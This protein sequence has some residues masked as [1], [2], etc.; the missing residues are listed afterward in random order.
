VPSFPLKRENVFYRSSDMT[1]AARMYQRD[2]IQPSKFGPTFDSESVHDAHSRGSAIG[3][4]GM[5]PSNHGRHNEPLP[6]DDEDDEYD[7]NPNGIL[8]LLEENARLRRL[9]IKQSCMTLKSVAEQ[10]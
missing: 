6:R 8:S 2:P 5:G 1:D 7:E 3:G 9:V 10:K 4:L